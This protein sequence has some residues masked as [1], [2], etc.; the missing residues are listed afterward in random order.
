LALDAPFDDLGA[1]AE[2]TGPSEAR[3]AL[4]VTITAAHPTTIAFANLLHATLAVRL[5]V[6]ALVE[7]AFQT[8]VLGA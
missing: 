4:A 7:V 5:R 6:V 3:V 2:A 1:G 8:A